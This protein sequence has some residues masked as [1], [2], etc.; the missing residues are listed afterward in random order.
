[1]RTECDGCGKNIVLWEKEDTM[2]GA[3][4]GDCGYYTTRYTYRFRNEADWL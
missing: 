1:M 4:C 3:E 2:I